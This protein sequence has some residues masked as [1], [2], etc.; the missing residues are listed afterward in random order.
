MAQRRRGAVVFVHVRVGDVLAVVIVVAVGV[1][2][3][4]VHNSH[5]PWHQVPDAVTG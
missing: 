5:C 4:A 1:A 3:G 2:D